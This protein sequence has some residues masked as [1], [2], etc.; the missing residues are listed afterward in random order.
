MLFSSKTSPTNSWFILLD[1][2]GLV[3]TSI[4][5]NESWVKELFK[6]LE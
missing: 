1:G 2:N 6:T 4:L 3:L 5:K